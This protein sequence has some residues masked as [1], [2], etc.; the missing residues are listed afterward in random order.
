MS[1]HEQLIDSLVSDLTPSRPPPRPWLLA[2]AWLLPAAIFVVAITGL[3]GPLRPNAFAQL[4]SEPRFLLETLMGVAAIGAAALVAFYSAVPGA[5]NRKWQI[6]ALWLMGL[7][8]LNYVVGLVNPALE[9]SML[10][11]RDHCVFETFIYALP[12]LV[13]GLIVLQQRLYPLQPLKSAALTGLVAGMLPALYMQIA[14]MYV[15]LHILK[16]HVAPGLAVALVAPLLMLAL[17]RWL[18]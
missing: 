12:P 13:L 2:L 3:L 9:P 4:A 15:P 6:A 14:C 7:W 8:L 10:G 11:K 1:G 5:I 18:G 16:F 17:R